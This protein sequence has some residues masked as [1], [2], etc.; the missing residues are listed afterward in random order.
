MKG[1]DDGGEGKGLLRCLWCFLV[2]LRGGICG[3]LRNSMVHRILF[4][5]SDTNWD[6]LCQGRLENFFP[7][8][9][10]VKEDSFLVSTLYF[11][12]SF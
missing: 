8:L 2:I 10:P 11:S 7:S 9:F 5:D 4:I 12:I 6:L 1:R 3:V